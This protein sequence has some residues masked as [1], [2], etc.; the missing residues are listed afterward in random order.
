MAKSQQTIYPT[1]KCFD[2]ALDFIEIMIRE[3]MFTKAELIDRFHLV[4]GIYESKHFQ[5]GVKKRFS[6]A[7]VW[8]K[9]DDCAIQSGLIDNG[10]L[11]YEMPIKAFRKRMVLEKET[12]YSIEQAYQENVKHNNYGPWVPEYLELCKDYRAGVA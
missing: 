3:S 5:G 2:D 9:Q 11:Y 7:W 8:D 10:L 1:G 6:H 4:H 12:V